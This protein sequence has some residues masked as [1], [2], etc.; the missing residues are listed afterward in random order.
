MIQDIA[1][2][3]FHNEFHPRPPKDGD[4]LLDFKGHE[5]ALKSDGSFFRWPE[6]SVREAMWLFDID[7]TGIFLCSLASLQP[8]YQSI[9]EM[10]YRQPMSEAFLAVTAWHLSCWYNDNRFCGSDGTRLVPSK[11]ERALQ[12]P[13][14][15][16][17]IYP[18]INPA[19]IVAIINDEDEI[20]VTR[21]ANGPYRRDALVA[22]Y[23]EIGET[24]EDTVHREVR[25]ET[26]LDVD[27]LH[28]YK[29]QP[30]GLS[31][32]LLAGFWCRTHGNI[33][34]HLQRSELDRAV[35]RKR[36]DAYN[37][38]GNP[39]LTAEMIHVFSQGGFKE[40]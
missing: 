29:S 7:D 15:G 9:F 35:W 39:S 13:H 17:I 24:L 14:C 27:E 25:E 26:G 40:E 36:S 1:P 32:S 12:C 6:A 18:R 20:L 19:V 16:K 23:C 8:H 11:T 33:P 28:Y 10:R 38:N 31:G 5:L 37:L 3:V 34:I 21:Y 30:W 4:I 2:A 22:G